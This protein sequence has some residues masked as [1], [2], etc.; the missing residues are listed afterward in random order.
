MS[1]V[2]CIIKFRDGEGHGW[3]EVHFRDPGTETP[4]LKVQ[5][6][7]LQNDICPKRRLLLGGDC[8]IIGLRASYPRDNLVASQ[9]RKTFLTGQSGEVSSSPSNS[10][11]IP[12]FDSTRTR[13]KTIHLRGFWDSVESS[14]AYHPEGGAANGWT[15]K[16][17]AYTDALKVK[18]YGWMSKDTGLSSRGKVTGYVSSNEDIVTFT[19]VKEVG[20]VLV[21]G[22][23]MPVSF[24]RLNKSASVLNGSILC[25]IV[26]AVTIRTVHPVAAGS[27]V[28]A[29]RFNLRQTSF[30]ALN[31]CEVP[32]LGERRM[33]DPLDHS[34]GRRK[35]KQRV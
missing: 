19:V 17:N 20:A 32:S 10:L 13:H 3:S 7:T 16:L 21:G 27:F 11:A 9:G 25:D 34:P 5:L 24:S 1:V 23:Q 6:D 8:A 33:G 18:S 4:D 29:G 28:S 22:R 12:C 26:D 35:A 31:G 15:D 30:V 2:K 14:D